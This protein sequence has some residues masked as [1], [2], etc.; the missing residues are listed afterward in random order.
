VEREVLQR[1]KEGEKEGRG[2]RTMLEEEKE[3]LEGM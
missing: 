2:R 1:S 3:M